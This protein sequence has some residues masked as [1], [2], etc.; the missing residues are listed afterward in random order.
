MWVASRW[1]GI[2]GATKY[3][4]GDCTIGG[5]LT[6]MEC[7]SLAMRCER[8]ELQLLIKNKNMLSQ[9]LDWP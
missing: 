4:C 1:Y 7:A 6:P 5:A 8:M 3:F 9:L 2:D